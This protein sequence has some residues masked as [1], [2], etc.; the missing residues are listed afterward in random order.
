MENHP[1]VNKTNGQAQGKICQFKLIFLG[2]SGVGKSSSVLRYIN[3]QFHENYE[4]TLGYRFVTHTVC[5]DDT[6]VK[7]VIWDTSGQSRYFSCVEKQSRGAHAAIVFYDITAG[8]TFSR[9]REWVDM[10]K[11]RQTSPNIVIALA[12]NKSD[13]ANKRMVE[14]DKAQAYAEENGLLFMETSAK[15]AMNVNEIFLAIAKKLLENG[16][17]G[18][19]QQTLEKSEE[20]GGCCNMCKQQ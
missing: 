5:L 19:G 6:T 18:A 4:A 7:F 8:N 20:R 1:G 14:F 2:Q 13:L 3:G 17:G 10:L 9:V 12:G 16:S 15:T 11:S